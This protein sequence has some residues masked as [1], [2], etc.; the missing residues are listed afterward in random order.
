MGAGGA[1]AGGGVGGVVGGVVGA[2]VAAAGR[3]G[4]A[5]SGAA[6]SG[7]SGVGAV[8]SVCVHVLSS[9]LHSPVKS[10]S[11]SAAVGVNTVGTSNNQMDLQ[12]EVATC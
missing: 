12:T 2:I 8:V 4:A 5:R 9:S 10:S 11:F 3:V 7:G 1:A 6:G